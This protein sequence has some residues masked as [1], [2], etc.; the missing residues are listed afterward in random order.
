MRGKRRKSRFN[1]YFY[2]RVGARQSLVSSLCGVR[3]VAIQ[4]GKAKTVFSFY[5]FFL[6]GKV[7]GETAIRPS[8]GGQ[9]R[10]EDCELVLA[11]R[12]DASTRI[13]RAG[14]S[15][16]DSKIVSIIHF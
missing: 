8:L 14:A 2:L 16:S 4:S 15:T 12:P 9:G 7:G 11:R 10:W 3:G 1:L 5:F 6:P 13:G